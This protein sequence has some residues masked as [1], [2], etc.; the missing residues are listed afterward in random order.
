MEIALYAL[1]GVLMVAGLAGL[2]LPALPGSVLMVAAVV[3]IA[4]AGQ[5]A[6]I[7]WITIA[8]TALLGA[9]M[10]IVD[11]VAALLG[12][13]AFGASRWALAGGAIGVVVGLFFGLPGI[14]LGPSIG[15]VAAELWKGAD[16]RRA[17]RSGA[18]VLVGFVAGTIAKIALAFI[19]LG[20]VGLALT[21]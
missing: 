7:G 9:F 11:H 15:A 3:V 10:W 14:I 13:K 12:A 19:M 17:A 6:R 2:V 4:W 8:I 1:G 21:T 16:L 18:G 5:F 20:V